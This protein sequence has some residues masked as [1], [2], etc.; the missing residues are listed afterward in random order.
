M[1]K[2]RHSQENVD[3]VQKNFDQTHTH[4]SQDA[5]SEHGQACMHGFSN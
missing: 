4:T 2:N 3:A 5:C 1:Q